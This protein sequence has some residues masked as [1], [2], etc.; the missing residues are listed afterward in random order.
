[1]ADANAKRSCA[2]FTELLPELMAR[3]EHAFRGKIADAVYLID[4]TGFRGSMVLDCTP[5]VRLA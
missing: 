4:A 1:L 2:V 3:C 5:N